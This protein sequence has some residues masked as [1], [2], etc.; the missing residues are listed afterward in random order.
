MFGAHKKNLK[1]IKHRNPQSWTISN[2][3]TIPQSLNN[4]VFYIAKLVLRSSFALSPF[5]PY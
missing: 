4:I 5:G 3:L 2:I 1:K